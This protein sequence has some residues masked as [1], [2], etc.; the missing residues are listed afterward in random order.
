[1][2]A[3]QVWQGHNLTGNDQLPYNTVKE[4]IEKYCIDKLEMD[5]N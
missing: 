2:A 3:F 5:E 1:M 4:E